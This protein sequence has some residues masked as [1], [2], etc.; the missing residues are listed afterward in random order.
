LCRT[1]LAIDLTDLSLEIFQI[2]APYQDKIPP[3][4][5]GNPTL[6]K[7]TLVEFYNNFLITHN[8]KVQ[9]LKSYISKIKRLESALETQVIITFPLSFS[10]SFK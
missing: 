8:R 7:T 6:K 10:L 1:A 2:Y 4:L 3:F 9:S 5:T